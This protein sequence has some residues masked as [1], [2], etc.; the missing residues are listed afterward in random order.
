MDQFF[1]DFDLIALPFSKGKL[2]GI[3]KEVGKYL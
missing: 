3:A 1:Q 2:V